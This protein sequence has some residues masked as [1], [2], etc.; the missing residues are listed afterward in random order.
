MT[1]STIDTNKLAEAL[2]HCNISAEALNEKM[3]MINRQIIEVNIGFMIANK[4]KCKYFNADSF[5]EI[6]MTE[7]ILPDSFRLKHQIVNFYNKQI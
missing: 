3:L 7:K 2:N 4:V 5:I 6:L 1:T